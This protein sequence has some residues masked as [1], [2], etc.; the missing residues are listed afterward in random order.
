MS[1]IDVG[2]LSLTQGLINTGTGRK[3]KRKAWSGKV[4]TTESERGKK[5]LEVFFLLHL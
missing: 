5:C 4:L 2:V 1:G 3:E